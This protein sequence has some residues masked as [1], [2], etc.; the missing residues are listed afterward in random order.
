MDDLEG[1]VILDTTAEEDKLLM[2]IGFALPRG[3]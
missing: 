2:K 3:Q 1:L